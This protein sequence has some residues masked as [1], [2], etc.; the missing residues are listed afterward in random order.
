MGSHRNRV[1]T[2]IR[3]MGLQHSGKCFGNVGSRRIYLNYGIPGEEVDAVDVRKEGDYLTGDVQSVLTPSPDRS[4]AFCQHFGLCGGCNWQHIHY[5]AQLRWKR[6]LLERALEKYAISA[7]EISPVVPSPQSTGYRHRLEF[8]FSAR[9]WYYETEGRVED[10]RDRLAMGFH[11]AGNAFKVLNIRE[12]HLLP[13]HCTALALSIHAFCRENGFS[14]FDPKD[15]TGLLRSLVI[16]ISATGQLMLIVVFAEDN[17]EAIRR[18]MEFILPAQP[19]VTS[20]FYTVTSDIRQNF[21]EAE[22]VSV[23]DT[24]AYITETV[25]NLTFRISPRSFYQPNPL[26]A[27][28]I[29]SRITE[30]AELQGTELIYDLYC[31]IGTISL[32]LATKAMRVV[33]IEG[34]PDAVEDARANAEMNGIDNAEFICGDILRTFTP[35]FV[36]QHGKPD[37]IVLDP[38]R[39]GT[40]IEIKKTILASEPAKIIYLSCDPLS[41]AN[42]LRMLTTAY[43]IR[44][45]EPFDQFPHTQHL[46]TLALLER[47]PD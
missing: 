31:G 45:L 16:R 33:G 29:F 38:P 4:V 43:T 14:Y 25:N 9:R 28:Q 17:P 15:H 6:Y 42:D 30:L 7:P 11:L 46:E 40:L 37:I 2:G 22:P 13:Q 27:A 34:S 26:Q 44:L 24:S 21:T 3:L 20:L 32:H 23:P 10:P 8:S 12:C 47:I 41:L 18:L 36:Q 1:Y 35:E 19:R 5:L 39:S